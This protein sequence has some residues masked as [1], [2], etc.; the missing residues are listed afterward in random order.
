MGAKYKNKHLKRVES[1]GTATGDSNLRFV[2][3][4]ICDTHNFIMS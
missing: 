4:N 2:G 3:R 1:A